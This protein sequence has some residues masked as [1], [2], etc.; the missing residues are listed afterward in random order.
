MIPLVVAVLLAG[1]I[2]GSASAARPTYTPGGEPPG[3]DSVLPLTPE[4]EASR[5]VKEAIIEQLITDGTDGGITPQYVCQFEPCEPSTK[6]LTVYARQQTKSY[7]CGPAVVQIVSNFSWG[8]TGTA[9]KY[10]QKTISDNWT[11][12]DANGQTYLGDEINGMNQAT[13]RPS[14][15]VY[16]QKHNPTFATGTG[17]SSGACITGVCPSQPA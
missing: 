8:K 14:N 3:D 7:Y 13:K 2:A 4:Q 6:Q 16:M 17:R 12:T 9:N 10:T 1:A 5:A 15:F 11:H